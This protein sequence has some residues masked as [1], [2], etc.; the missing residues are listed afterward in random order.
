[1]VEKFYLSLPVKDVARSRAFFAALGHTF[2]PQFTGDGAACLVMTDTVSVML[3]PHAR[4]S[5]LSAKPI[6]DTQKTSAGLIAINLRSRAEVDAHLDAAVKAGGT[7]AHGRED[8]GFMYMG[9]FYDL[10]GHG[11]GIHWMDPDAAMPAAQEETA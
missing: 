5:E 4:Y 10:D 7:E 6:A 8:M 3:V 9:G 2:D 11:W 1:M